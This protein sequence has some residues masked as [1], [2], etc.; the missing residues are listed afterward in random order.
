MIRKVRI[1]LPAA[2]GVD[3]DQSLLLRGVHNEALQFVPEPACSPSPSRRGRFVGAD[4]LEF[5]DN[6]EGNERL[7]LDDEDRATSEAGLF[8]TL[9]SAAKREYQRVPRIK[10]GGLSRAV[11]HSSKSATTAMIDCVRSRARSDDALDVALTFK[12]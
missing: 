11:D 7:I 2:C 9:P 12:G 5:R 8:H 6:V 4:L 1:Q 3:L 10:S